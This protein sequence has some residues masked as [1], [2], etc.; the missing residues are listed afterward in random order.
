MGGSSRDDECTLGSRASGRPRCDRLRDRYRAPR[1][2]GMHAFDHAAVDLNHAL[3]RCSPAGRTP[4]SS[5]A[6]GDFVG[7]GENTAL[8]GSI[9]FGWISVLPS[10]PKS[11]ACAH[12]ARE[13]FGVADVVVDAVEDIDA[14]MRARPAS[15]SRS[16]AASERVRH[17]ARARLLGEIV[18]PEHE[19][20]EPRLAS[21]AAAAIARTLKIAAGV[22]IIAQ[23]RVRRSA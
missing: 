10:K 1:H 23:M 8:H 14:G 20:G 6:P 16:T 18:E 13:A 19:A 5:C 11:R 3:A 22:S 2:L 17:L 15:R 21:F 7:A 4:R 9:W 12:S